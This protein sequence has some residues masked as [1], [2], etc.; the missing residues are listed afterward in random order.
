MARPYH[1]AEPTFDKDEARGARS[2]VARMVS[3]LAATRKVSVAEMLDV[4]H[5]GDLGESSA[6]T[7]EGIDVISSSRRQNHGDEH[8][9]VGR[10]GGTVACP[11]EDDVR[12]LDENSRAIVYAFS[13]DSVVFTKAGGNDHGYIST[14]CTGTDSSLE[15]SSP[16]ASPAAISS[17]AL[18]TRG[19]NA[20][21]IQ[22][23]NTLRD[24]SNR[25]LTGDGRSYPLL[26]SVSQTCGVASSEES[27]DKST[28]NG[29]E[30][31]GETSATAPRVAGAALLFKHWDLEQHGSVANNAGRTIVNVL[32]FADGFAMDETAV[33]AGTGGRVAP[34][35]PGWGLGRL[36]MRLYGDAQ[37]TAG[38]ACWGTTL[39]GVYTGSFHL[40]DITNGTGSVAHGV[41]SLPVGVRHLRITAWW[42]EV[43]TG[44]GESKA[45]VN[46]SLVYKDASGAT[47]F[48]SVSNGSEHVLRMQYDR[49][50]TTFD[51]P[52]S[53]EVSL[54][55]WCGDVPVEARSTRGGG[56]DDPRFAWRVVHLAWY[57]ET[58]DDPTQI[59]CVASTPST[60]CPAAPI[61]I[62]TDG[63]SSGD[64]DVFYDAEDPVAPDDDDD[65]GPEISAGGDDEPDGGYTDGD[66]IRG[67]GHAD[68]RRMCAA[69][70]G[71]VRGA[72]RIATGVA[73]SVG[74]SPV[75]KS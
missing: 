48:D 44:E 4:I 39:R 33:P 19:F 11:T 29:Y 28:L 45:Q 70:D 34:P 73:P 14:V 22:E 38:Q 36:R 60:R 37:Q 12:G 49:D 3:G 66:S 71:A 25:G 6:T 43:N 47:R 54:C 64:D 42:L 46:L 24:A 5:N 30:H 27:D 50:D 74:V 56:L 67:M 55:L 69:A 53:G 63:G 72:L 57:W 21:E 32:N 40:I 26:A 61:V 16:G 41:G 7:Y 52:P 58:N 35:G 68:L 17:S 59:A 20:G 15:I 75:F 62:G 31:H 9:G 1:Y 65:D 13:N 23:A 51:C 18:Q 10:D 2:G 8:K